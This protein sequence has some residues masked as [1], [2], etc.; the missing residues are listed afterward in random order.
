MTKAQKQRK[1]YRLHQI[2]KHH[3]RYESQNY[4]IMVPYDF[5]VENY[6]EKVGRALKQLQDLK[7]SLQIEIQ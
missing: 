4:T 7:Y 6:D 3:F 5:A 1:C 2:I